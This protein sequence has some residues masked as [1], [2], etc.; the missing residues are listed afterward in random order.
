M[1]TLDTSILWVSA[2]IDTPKTS[3]LEPRQHLG[4]ELRLMAQATGADLVDAGGG[5]WTPVSG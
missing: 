3:R 5:R 1:K 4:G 2:R